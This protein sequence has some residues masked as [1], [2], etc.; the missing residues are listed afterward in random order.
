MP[1]AELVNDE[2]H[3]KTELRDKDRIRLIPGANWR[4]RE[5]VW[6][7]PVSWAAC[8]TLRGVF[9]DDLAIGPE[10]TEWAWDEMNSRVNPSLALRLS[11]DLN[12][13]T[14]YRSKTGFALFPFQRAG[15]KFLATAR[16]AL[17]AD[18]M[19]TGK[20]VQTI[21]GL[22]TLHD[23]GFDVFPVIII[24]PNSMK[25]TWKREFDEWWPGLAVQVIKGSATERRKQLEASWDVYVMNWESVLL[26]SRL[27]PYGSVALRRCP[28]HGGSDPKV[29]TARCEVHIKELNK[30]AF[31]SVVVDEAHR[32]KN[33]AAKQT[34]AIW[35][36][37]H[38]ATVENRFA[39]TGTPIA[40]H[41]GDLWSIMHGI[42][43]REYPTKTKYVDRYGLLSW[44]SYGGMDIIGIRPDTKDE[45]YSILDPRMRR[46]PKDLV[47]P[48]LPPKIPIRRYAEMSA[49]Q[50]KQYEMMT[51]DLIARLDS[52]LLLSTNALAQLTRLVQFSSS[53]ADVTEVDDGSGGIEVKVRLTAP[54]NKVDELLNLVEDL[55]D[56]EPI[57]VMAASRQLIMLANAELERKKISTRLIVGGI[58]PDQRQVA[59]DDFQS[60]RA[61][62][63]LCTIAAGGVGI[64]LT[65]S[66]TM[67][68]LQR[69]WSMID[70]RQ[71]VDRVHRI[72][73]EIHESIRV[74]D[75]VSPGTVEER[76][77]LML[78]EKEERLEEILRDRDTLSDE[79]QSLIA[80]KADAERIEKLRHRIGEL[81]GSIRAKE[82]LEFN[83]LRSYLR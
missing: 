58:T 20:T 24:A 40:Q 1:T 9:H 10:L 35:A 69:S 6:S 55:P 62:I 64:T 60:G 15:A 8:K 65:R 11:T 66:R 56:D 73:S 12:H 7:V 68:F 29:T 4:P 82:V 18:E 3:I 22:K 19:G 67:V 26:H 76:Q 63:I 37:Q 51:N 61:R 16:Q 70:N 49:K 77:L 83:D 44:N 41:P 54:S 53:C 79:L 21:M 17:L 52:G 48:F 25:I 5:Y 2:I 38:Q 42:S 36:V 71:A 30:I 78:R 74:I 47:L 31:R 59:V 14:D 28:E 81:D 50:R 32:M 45:F 57:V 33:P 43:P 75:I 72:G 13:F 39:L 34:R 27:A 80:Q 46:M 23:A